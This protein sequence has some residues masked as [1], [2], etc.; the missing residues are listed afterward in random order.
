MY[1]HY[2][3]QNKKPL[4]L[5]FPSYLVPPS[6]FVGDVCH[7]RAWWQPWRICSLR[8]DPKMGIG[9]GRWWRCQDGLWWQGRYRIHPPPCSDTVWVLQS[10]KFV[11]LIDKGFFL[12]LWE[13]FRSSW[14]WNLG[15]YSLIFYVLCHVGIYSWDHL[16][17]QDVWSFVGH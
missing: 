13:S 1:H 14:N 8:L 9:K 12:N 11:N 15:H 3:S 17:W 6:D 2:N 10:V 16:A 7:Q 4:S 5:K